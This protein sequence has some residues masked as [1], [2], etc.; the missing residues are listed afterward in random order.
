MFKTC[1]GAVREKS[2]LIHNITNAVTVNDVANLLLACGASPIMSDE[3]EE[4]EDI[5]S[6]CGGLNI[7]IGTLNTRSIEAMHLAGKKAN[8]LGRVVLLDPVGVGAS[9]LRTKT[10]DDLLREVRFTAV[11]GNMSEIKALFQGSRTLRGVDCDLADAVN[12]ENLSESVELVGS[13]SE[14]LHCIIAVTGKLDLISDGKTCYVIRNGQ[15]EMEKVTGTGCQLAGMMTAFLAA[16]PEN[17]LEAAAAAVAVMG[18][19]GEIGWAYRKPGDGNAAYR[20]HIIDAVYHM[21]GETLER[22]ARY[23]VR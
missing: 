5:A 12:E 6:L 14:K 18:V 21:D 4:A 13:L 23:E 15:P 22:K 11:K 10:V 9:R 20:S 3:P 19:A 1:L 7:N 2:P 17:P 16:N 8:A